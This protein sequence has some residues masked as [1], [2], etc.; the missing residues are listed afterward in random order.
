MTKPLNFFLNIFFKK[1]YFLNLNVFFTF[2]FDYEYM[3]VTD[4]SFKNYV[5][6]YFKV[7]IQKNIN[8]FMKLFFQFKIKKYI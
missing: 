7:K 1:Y 3:N 4:K 8:K 5:F 2:L 6:Q